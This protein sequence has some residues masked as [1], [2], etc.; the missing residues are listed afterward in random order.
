VLS[1]HLSGGLT[2]VTKNLI[3]DRQ[4]AGR[5]LN[6]GAPKY[7]AGV[8][9]EQVHMCWKCQQFDAQDAVSGVPYF[10]IACNQYIFPLIPP[11]RDKCVSEVACRGFVV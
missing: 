3:Q 4:P 7:E 1:E 11:S 10:V 8:W 9:V 2:K 5:D 6:P